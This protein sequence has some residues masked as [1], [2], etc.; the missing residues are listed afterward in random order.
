MTTRSVDSQYSSMGPVQTSFSS[1]LLLVG[2]SGTTG[3]QSLFAGGPV[4]PGGT[5]GPRLLV[6]VAAATGLRP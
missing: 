6:L 4:P 2:C 3:T 5:P 1:N